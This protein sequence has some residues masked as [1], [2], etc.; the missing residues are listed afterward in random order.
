MTERYFSKKILDKDKYFY[1]VKKLRNSTKL[2]ISSKHGSDT[3]KMALKDVLYTTLEV[4]KVS[5]PSKKELFNL[6]LLVIW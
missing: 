1:L 4:N 6:R 5:I 3:F 2:L